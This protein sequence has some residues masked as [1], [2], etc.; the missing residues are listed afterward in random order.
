MYPAISIVITLAQRE[1]MSI[2]RPP[3]SIMSVIDFDLHSMQV[4]IDN[5]TLSIGV[6]AGAVHHRQFM[7]FGL[8][9]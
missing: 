8:E 5:V 1:G 6:C 2:E 3:T 9:K 7:A 4:V